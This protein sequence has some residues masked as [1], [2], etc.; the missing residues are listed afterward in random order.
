MGRIDPKKHFLFEEKLFLRTVTLK[1]VNGICCPRGRKIA[2]YFNSSKTKLFLS[3]ILGQ[4]AL[5]VYNLNCV[6]IAEKISASK[7]GTCA[8]INE[9][10]E[11]GWVEM[12]KHAGKTCYKASN[13]MMQQYE[14]YFD[15]KE[16]WF[17]EVFKD[18]C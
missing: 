6:E 14:A 12:Y 2:N 4:C 17:K 3:N 5:G 7:S 9:C 1:D 15:L 8:I 18:Y 10:V 11:A 16:Q 13:E